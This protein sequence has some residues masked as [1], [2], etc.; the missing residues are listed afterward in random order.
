MP[1]DLQ[2]HLEPALPGDPYRDYCQWPYEPLSSPSSQA[3]RSSALLYQSF[4]HAGVGAEMAAFCAA[5]RKGLGPF[6]TVWGIKFAPGHLSW[7]FYVYDYA[8][9]GRRLSL[10]RFA[11]AAGNH[12]DL[13]VPLADDRPYFMFSVEIGA[14][15][16]RG[17]Q[18]VDQVD[19]YIGNP[20]SSVSSGI[21]YGLTRA[22]LELRNFYF[23][24]DAERDAP[25]I[26]DKIRLNAHLPPGR[27]DLDQILWPAITQVKTIVV[28]NKRDRDGLYFSRIPVG[29][30]ETCLARLGAPLPLQGFLQQNRDRF[31]H[32]LF[33]VGYDYAPDPAGGIRYL[34]GSYYGLL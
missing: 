22:G 2:R 13:R 24:F 3:W 31:S 29:H 16:I 1:W 33:D 34:K 9:L 25:H 10:S 20:G 15:H 27:L 6:N 18:P 7:E 26:A 19:L 5:L 32:L 14:A 21:C 30:L 12:L 8:G 17:H 4:D 28:A 23:F 11:E